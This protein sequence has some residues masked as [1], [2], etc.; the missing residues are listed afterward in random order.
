MS[1]AQPIN[2][3]RHDG[4]N[5]KD[6]ENSSRQHEHMPIS[7]ETGSLADC[8]YLANPCRSITA[9]LTI[10]GGLVCSPSPHMRVHYKQSRGVG[11]TLFSALENRELH[12]T[13]KHARRSSLLF[14]SHAPKP[15]TLWIAM[16]H[17]CFRLN[18]GATT[19]TCFI[20][21]TQE[22]PAF[23]AEP[24]VRALWRNLVRATT[25]G[26][27][28]SVPTVSPPSWAAAVAFDTRRDL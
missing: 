13:E 23:L 18:G 21:I 25:H 7:G 11:E 20:Q 2:G 5:T 9:G 27:Y 22:H 26:D 6:A 24:R 14:L 17:T 10:G 28:S 3:T 19:D 12:E 1:H 16:E 8:K 4:G 15:T